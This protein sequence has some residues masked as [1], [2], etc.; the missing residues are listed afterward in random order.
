[1]SSSLKTECP[2]CGKALRMSMEQA[3]QRVRCPACRQAFA[4]S[5]V[6][7]SGGQ[8][9]APSQV[10]METQ[11]DVAAD[12]K[13]TVKG[14][15]SASQSARGNV[16][17]F[18]LHE[19]LGQGGFGQVY[20]AYDPV[21]E[22]DVAIKL[23]RFTTSNE[24]Q[25]RRFVLEA[26]AAACLKHPNIVGVFESG[27]LDGQ[28]Y[29]ASEFVAGETL[30]TRLKR[31]RPSLTD[32]ATW[33]RDLAEALAYAHREGIVHRDIK[34][35]NIM[36]SADQRPQ[37][38]DFGLAKRMDDNSSLTVEGSVLGTPAYMSPEQARGEL[39]QVGPASDQYSLGATLYELLTGQRPFEGPPHAV[40]AAVTSSEPPRPQS[41]NPGIPRDLE[42]ICLRAMSKEP[43][44]RYTDLSAL[45]ADLTRW[46]EGRPVL[47]RPATRSEQLFQWCR[48]QPVIA[49]LSAGVAVILILGVAIS[50]IFAIR[51]TAEEERANLKAVE[52]EENRQ[53]A[54]A[55][56]A[57]AIA[58]TYM[59]DMN[60][61]Q[62][63]WDAS[64]TGVV[65]QL[66]DR[67]RPKPEEKDLRGW[68][69]YYQSRL[70]SSDLR[71]YPP[72]PPESQGGFLG[73]GNA[74]GVAFSA[75]GTRIASAGGGE[76]RIWDAATGNKLSTL[77]SATGG[78]PSSIAYHP[79][80][81]H[82]AAGDDRGTITVWSLATGQVASSTTAHENP[83]SG[84]LYT[85]KCVA[86]SPSGALLASAGS[87]GVIKVWET[88][89]GRELHSP[90]AHINACESVAFSPDESHLASVGLNHVLPDKAY[91]ALKVWNTE[92]GEQIS[93]FP[94][95]TDDIKCVAFSPDGTQV[96][97]ASRDRLVKLWDIV[98]GRELRT[99]AGHSNH[100]NAVAFS[101]SGKLVASGSADSSIRIWEVA[102]G[103]ELR[104]I[105][106]HRGSINDLAF[107]PDGS[108]LASASDDGLVKLWGVFTLPEQR[109]I[110][111]H[112][113][114][115]YVHTA[116]SPDGS[117]M[118]SAAESGTY[119]TDLNSGLQKTSFQPDRSVA[120]YVSNV[121]RCMALDKTS[122]RLA[123]GDRNG[124]VQI[125][126]V[127]TNATP[128]T[129][130]AHPQ[131]VDQILFSPDGT[132]LGTCGANSERHG[133]LSTRM[134]DAATGKMLWDASGFVLNI[135]FHPHTATL[136]TVQADSPTSSNWEIRI[137]DAATGNLVRT[138]PIRMARR[139]AFSPDGGLLA[140]GDDDG[141]V[142]LLDALNFREVRS[143][144]GHSQSI[145]SLAFHPHG[146][147]MATGSF[148]ETAKLWNV[149]T[150]QELRTFTG[151]AGQVNCVMFT[152]DGQRLI[153]TSEGATLIVAD[154]SELK[155]E[156]IIELEARNLLAALRENGCPRAD[157]AGLIANN[158][159]ISEPV[160]QK[161]MALVNDYLE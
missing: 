26:K 60:L 9:I 14:P 81:T 148:D 79:Q 113:G 117:L 16:G 131:W 156:S 99:L 142:T 13:S 72:L 61:A 118:A 6:G 4:V 132:Y 35:E 89:T 152:A 48:R 71:T 84:V 134:W 17:R 95:H 106:G 27:E 120:S 93:S 146:A 21:L 77:K 105:R 88:A 22:R 15:A 159:T 33:I 18:I 25:R 85:V 69:W 141:K 86:F 63:N 30:A 8:S 87:N 114:H 29:I 110:E 38:M 103:R 52:A 24:A 155:P 121:H 36:L 56:A 150:G 127:S 94:A 149:L 58:Y 109:R 50:S 100:V 116:I 133:D 137:F 153:S 59:A 126:T 140:L 119:L 65:H 66:L 10:A 108:V 97:T 102:T 11:G 53:L 70:C 55:K 135:A 157:A 139:L 160:R 37:I 31:E 42:A 67:W 115:Y 101:P 151:Y 39:D 28:P 91:H 128:L 47:A 51:A 122:R 68:E 92:T 12:A 143:F 62:M 107:S 34:P 161:A 23:P 49:G 7:F 154:A 41:V 147:R 46:L 3:G 73:L 32:A 64:R 20:R 80:G 45:A 145:T 98:A 83:E 1:M 54:E 76:V 40:I 5:A 130:R 124:I 96:A 138:L 44:R 75:D 57:E 144:S 111:G 136:A 125:R 112:D 74:Q 2:H 43:E 129:F 82:I 78:L 19:E 104:I 90:K 123:T 158:G